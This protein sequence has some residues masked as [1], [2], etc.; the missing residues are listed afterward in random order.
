MH[1]AVAL[2]ERSDSVLSSTSPS[3]SST[4]F[5]AFLLSPSFGVAAIRFVDS[6]VSPSLCAAACVTPSVCVVASATAHSLKEHGMPSSV[7]QHSSVM[8][9][10]GKNTPHLTHEG[11]PPCL[12]CCCCC[13]CSF[14]L[15]CLCVCFSL[16]SFTASAEHHPKIEVSI[17]L[18]PHHSLF[19]ARLTFRP[20]FP[21]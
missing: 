12:C 11:M 7:M 9:W 16:N 5:V 2:I 14:R 3:F 17:W 8:S 20:Q 19:D 15:F 21:K 6:I 18:L 10:N 1:Y 13:C 4:S